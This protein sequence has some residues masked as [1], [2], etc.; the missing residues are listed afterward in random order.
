[1]QTQ[2]RQL[3]LDSTNPDKTVLLYRSFLT[4]KS[5]AHPQK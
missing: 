3:S 4:E 2:F 5:Y 1:M